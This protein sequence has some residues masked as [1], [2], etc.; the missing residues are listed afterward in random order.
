MQRH[1]TLLVAYELRRQRTARHRWVRGH[2]HHLGFSVGEARL[3]PRVSRVRQ[4]VPPGLA[5]ERRRERASNL[6]QRSPPQGIRR[7]HMGVQDPTPL[8][9]RHPS[10]PGTLPGAGREY[11]RPDYINPRGLMWADDKH[12]GTPTSCGGDPAGHHYNRRHERDPT[13]RP[14]TNK[15]EQRCG[16]DPKGWLHEGA[17]PGYARGAHVLVGSSLRQA[18]SSG[19]RGP[20]A[21]DKVDAPSC[22]GRGAPV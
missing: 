7:E 22:L 14:R 8:G 5:T 6:H 11:Q 17:Q 3:C 13:D 18:S 21:L 10:F 19:D 15:Y 9:G 20:L 16:G 12:T 1:V 2:A 4:P